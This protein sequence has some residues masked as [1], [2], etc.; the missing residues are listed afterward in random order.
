MPRTLKNT[1]IKGLPPKVQ[2]QMRDA[3]TGSFPAHSR[4]ASDNRTG[5]FAARYDDNKTVHFK[6]YAYSFQN[7]GFNPKTT[8]DAPTGYNLGSGVI[9]WWRFHD[10]AF[11]AGQWK[12]DFNNATPDHIALWGSN[13]YTTPVDLPPYY[14]N[15]TDTFANINSVATT[16]LETNGDTISTTIYTNLSGGDELTTQTSP[17]PTFT[18][19]LHVLLDLDNYGSPKIP[20]AWRGI[21]NTSFADWEL[22]VTD[23]GAVEFVVF[24]NEVGAYRVY[25]TTS[26]NLVP[27]DE[28]RHLAVTVDSTT[29]T[30]I[31]VKIYV[32]GILQSTT[33]PVD[34]GWSGFTVTQDQFYI[35]AV[36][37]EDYVGTGE[38]A[39]LSAHGM[40]DEVVLA[41]GVATQTEVNYLY[42]GAPIPGVKTGIILPAGLQSENA[43][44]FQVNQSGTLVANK[45]MTTDLVVDG[46]VRKGVG[47]KFITFTPG[48]DFQPFRDDW[49]LAADAK[50]VI[51][52]TIQNSFYATGSKLAD[53]GEG[54]DQPLWSKSK[55]EIDLTPSTAHSFSLQQDVSGTMGVNYPMA[56]WNFQTKKFEG[57]GSGAVFHTYASGSTEAARFTRLKALLEDQCIAF[58]ESMWEIVGPPNPQ[59]N[60]SRGQIISNFGFPYHPKFHATSS[61]SIPVSDLVDTP[62]LVEKVVL[63]FSGAFGVNSLTYSS[64]QYTYNAAVAGFFILNQRKPF[65]VNIPEAQEIVYQTPTNTSFFTGAFVPGEGGYSG[66]NTTRDL[67]TT[68]RICSI[69][70]GSF[71]ANETAAAVNADLTM[72]V[73][74]RSGFFQ[75]GPPTWFGRFQVSGTVRSQIGNQGMGSIIT[76]TLGAT[77]FMMTKLEKS[78]R[79][80]IF[81]AT[82]RSYVS[83]FSSGQIAR[84]V[85]QDGW[86]FN[87]LTKYSKPN[88]YLI[89]PG[90]R[91]IFGW[92]VPWSRT[93][94]ED[95]LFNTEFSGQGAYL[96][97]AP[98]PSKVILYGS[99]IGEN[100]EHHDTLNQL[101]TSA[102]IHEIV[103]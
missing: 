16:G 76:N 33:I 25:K 57:I 40:F 87:V 96:Q 35:G 74:Q 50:S 82:G 18:L 31:T 27:P 21:R 86:T 34:T 73:P 98:A 71:L 49:N 36:F 95:T 46:V 58:G 101:L 92:Q 15:D 68:L 88:P 2:L 44:F 83:D 22:L 103:E 1:R 94:N 90:D 4:L 20:V 5:R 75:F 81:G 12:S 6:S 14:N 69:I 17:R 8:T 56:Y 72:V 41:K 63:E 47:D 9:L 52:G 39:G 99:R 79:S 78:N 91:L 24:T 23:T 65:A 3:V 85:T 89:Q 51:S 29:A 45:E 66:Y 54:F 93:L 13:S 60:E 102:T 42:L 62:F 43:A 7:S 80:G 11:S 48:Q 97:F 77:T 61:N 70:T 67:L 38:G 84:S 100:R 59:L 55:I 19:S 32:N 37:D 53:V 28:W 30:N 10:K 26:D 64:K